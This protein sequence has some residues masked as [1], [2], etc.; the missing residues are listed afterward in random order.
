MQ[1]EVTTGLFVPG[2][3]NGPYEKNGKF[4]EPPVLTCQGGIRTHQ[5]MCLS[6]SQLGFS[7]VIPAQ[8][9]TAISVNTAHGFKADSG[10]LF[11]LFIGKTSNHQKINEMPGK[12]NPTA[13]AGLPALLCQQHSLLPGQQGW[14]TPLVR[15]WG[16]ET[17]HQT[18]MHDC[19]RK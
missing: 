1:L 9:F 19:C 13:K 2:L 5:A 17:R 8:I 3:E 6:L 12:T 16:Y 14:K 10:T 18:R 15:S 4:R 7:L 11:A